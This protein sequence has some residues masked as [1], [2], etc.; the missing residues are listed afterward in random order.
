MQL[1]VLGCG[2][3]GLVTGACL[4]DLGHTVIGVDNDPA[5]VKMLQQGLSPIYE[6]G[7]EPLVQA[8]MKEGRLSFTS[9]VAHAVAQSDVVFICVP[10]PPLPDGNAD[11]SHVESVMV[12]IA[13]A[14]RRDTV[15]VEKS[16]VPVRTAQWLKQLAQDHLPPDVE[17]DLASNPEFLSEGTAVRDFFKPDRIVIGAESPRAAGILVD[18]YAPLNA[19]LLITDIESA[20]LIKHASNA[21]L[22]TKISFINAVAQVCERTGA[23]IEK[24]AKGI[25]LDKRIGEAFL[26]AG[27]GYGGICFPKDVAAFIQ[28]AAQKGYDFSLLK[29]V[30]EINHGQRRHVL[31]R[32]MDLAGPAPK[33]VAVLG[34]TFKP[35]TD[36]LRDAPSLTLIKGLLE[37]G[38]KIQA[39]DPVALDKA[40]PLLADV[41][42]CATPLEAVA[43][44][45][46]TV[47]VT[48]WETYKT[49][50]MVSVR[51]AMAQPHLVDARNLYDPKRMRNLGFRYAGVGRSG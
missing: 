43:G 37:A 15:I 16:T 22:A 9:D 31:E 39:H 14:V 6:P 25:G 18:L 45:H 10:T 23:D 40:H 34:L 28:I 8:N 2:Y 50:D 5:K 46:C 3:V 1:A 35:N 49:L 33:T 7:L 29:A 30:Q 13:R 32:A 17:V 4:A 48:E 36:D 47:V 12:E 38:Y 21:F 24:V 41:Q 26:K 20:E 19:P 11:L 27:I 51:S 44:A 42:L